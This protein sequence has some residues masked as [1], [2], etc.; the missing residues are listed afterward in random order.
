MAKT[1]KERNDYLIEPDTDL[2]KR[3]MRDI[4]GTIPTKISLTT[5]L[6]NAVER[7]LKMKNVA[8]FIAGNGVTRSSFADT[9][10]TN[11]TE[12]ETAIIICCKSAQ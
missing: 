1:I 5:L 8:Y 11:H 7:H 3:C 10:T 4:I 6:M 9:G 2:S 12:G